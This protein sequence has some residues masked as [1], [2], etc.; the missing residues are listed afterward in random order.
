MEN[1]VANHNPQTE[2]QNIPIQNSDDGYSDDVLVMSE[3]GELVPAEPMVDSGQGERAPKPAG[4]DGQTTEPPKYYRSQQ[5]VDAAFSARLTAEREKLKPDLEFTK[6]VRTLFNGLT[7]DQIEEK[8]L[9]VAASSYAEEKGIPVEVAS[10]LT[11]LRMNLP[12][13]AMPPAEAK[14]QPEPA[15]DHDGRIKA[16]ADEASAINQKYGIDMGS[17]LAS[18]KDLQRRVF[19]DG[20][21]LKDVLID[22]LQS[23]QRPARTVTPIRSPNGVGSVSE[24]VGM[25]DEQYERIR[26]AVKGGATVRLS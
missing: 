19:G 9:S 18:D 7:D 8:L 1:T 4:D 17:I 12:S 25:S 2:S 21:S 24:S 10:E 26:A 5:E 15:N 3:N 22:Y 6:R 23:Q 11:N 20:E 14:P 13:A 16:L